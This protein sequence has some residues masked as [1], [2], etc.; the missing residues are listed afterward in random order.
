MRKYFIITLFCILY[1]YEFN[2]YSMISYNSDSDLY[3][4]QN[5][6]LTSMRIG[7]KYIYNKSFISITS[8]FSY[9]IFKGSNIIFDD[10]NDTQALGKVEQSPGLSSDQ[11]NYFS[12]IFLSKYSFET[13]QWYANISSPKWGPGKSSLILSGKVPPFLNVGYIWKLNEKIS[14]EHM[15]GS[16]VSMIEDTTFNNL[17]NASNRNPY[18][19]RNIFLHRLSLDIYPN[20]SI[21]LYEMIVYGGN[22]S[23][24]PYYMIPFIPF[25]PTQT[26]LGDIDND[27]IGGSMEYQPMDKMSVYT[28]LIIDEWS[29]SYTF[30]KIHKNWFLYQLGIELNDLIISNDNLVVEYVW[31]EL[32]VYKHR[33]EINDYYSYG[34]PLGFWGGPHSEQ[35]SILYKT[36]Y[37]DITI[38][39]GY[40]FAKRGTIVDSI[41]EEKYSNDFYYDRYSDGY[42]KKD[43]ISLV[44]SYKFMDN[45]KLNFG[46]NHIIWNNPDFKIN[47]IDPIDISSSIIKNDFFLL[48]DYR[49]K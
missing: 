9:N 14:Y 48:L 3:P 5:T 31:S 32:R 37:K 23:I 46:Y 49:F 21:S 25:L 44:F 26:Y 22:R 20:F 28:T 34:Y 29:P 45:I 10:F 41:T 30:N 36:A 24:E 15:Y 13:I 17:Y 18:Y 12:A 35:F 8:D 11:Y 4:T 1:G 7:V 6:D 38:S 39:P 16:L 33:F 47:E 40:T 2:P 42:E 27:L 43:I 19:K